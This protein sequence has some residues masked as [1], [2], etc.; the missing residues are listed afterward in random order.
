MH[1]KV[2]NWLPT[3]SCLAVRHAWVR[4][5]GI[6]ES[7]EHDAVCCYGVKTKE[8]E[9][10]TLGSMGNTLRG[11]Q[12]KSARTPSLEMVFRASNGL[13]ENCVVWCCSHLNQIH[14]ICCTGCDCS[15]QQA[16]CY[17]PTNI[18]WITICP[19]WCLQ[20]PIQTKSQSCVTI[21]TLGQQTTPQQ[22]MVHH[23]NASVQ[24]IKY[25]ITIQLQ[26]IQPLLQNHQAAVREEAFL[27]TILSSCLC[28]GKEPRLCWGQTNA[29]ER[30]ECP[31]SPMPA[32]TRVGNSPGPMPQ[33]V[34][35]VGKPFL[36][37]ATIGTGI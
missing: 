12:H 24:Q 29:N 31:Y 23:T 30:H 15:T 8:T 5:E 13:K 37:K 10:G 4:C 14:R 20:R 6:H 22:S 7:P 19:Y 18:S 17:L 3:N 11:Q 35:L 25:A 9:E 36:P 27:G 32:V 16:C 28:S 33:L 34:A 26:Y 21:H 1:Q 2:S